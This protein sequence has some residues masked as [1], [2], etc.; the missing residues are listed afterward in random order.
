MVLNVHRNHKAHSGRGGEG[1]GVWRLGER[2][3]IYTYRYSVTTRMIPVLRWAAMRAILMFHNCDGQ[4]HMKVSI[5]HNLRSERGAEA[6][7]SRG[8][9]AYHQPTALPLGQTGSQLLHY[10][11]GPF[12]SPQACLRRC[13]C[14]QALTG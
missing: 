13:V 2:E 3:I 4:S 9:S 11:T 1:K 5:D 6:D 14:T 8:P 7:S 12:N 10:Y